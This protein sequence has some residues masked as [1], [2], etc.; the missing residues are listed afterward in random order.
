MNL[1]L[2][3]ISQKHAAEFRSW[4]A[5]KQ[6]VK[7]TLS[8]FLPHRDE[9]WVR[10]YISSLLEDNTTWN[11]AII[12]DNSV[13]GYCGLSNLSEENRSGE[14]FIIIGNRNYWNCGFGTLAGQKVLKYGFSVLGLH[15]IWLTV[16]EVNQGAIRSYDKLGFTEEGRM[17]E[18]CF[19]DGTFHDKVV[20][21]IIEEQWHNNTNAA[22]ARSSRR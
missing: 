10:L 1:V 16:S 14:Y 12:V 6:A 18:A 3:D 5:D 13:I 22:E 15:R 8:I 7:Y 20:M 21:S 9:Q 19:R 2:T 17:K 11:Q 4:I